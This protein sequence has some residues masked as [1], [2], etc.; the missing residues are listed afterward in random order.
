MCMRAVCAGAGHR[1][2]CLALEA[3]SLSCQA[4]G[5]PVGPWRENTLCS[6]QCPERSSPAD[7]LDS[8]SN[9]CL[10][11]LQPGSSAASCE[12]GCQ[13]S[14][15]RVF[16]GG[17]CVPYSQC[18][19][20]LHDKYIK[21]DELLYMKD[22]TQRCW[23][24]PLGGVMCEEVSCSPGQQCALRSGSWGCY[25]RPEVCELRGGLHVSTL[26]GQLLHLEPQLSYSLMSVCDE[27]SVQWFSLISYHGPCDGS[28]SRL[29][30]VFQILLHGMSLAI[31]QG[32]V[33]VNGHFVSLP[34][35]LA[36]GLTLTSGVNQKKSEVTVILRRDA[37]LEWELQIDIGVTMVTVKVPLWYSGKLCGLC[38]NLN[39]LYSHNS[40]KSW[41]LSDFPG[42]GCSG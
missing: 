22:C 26:S 1:A 42:C 5:I 19:C 28:S 20:T 15:D 39:D 41:V 30:T 9:S 29:V 24:H 25:E 7:C 18:G 13:C 23:C 17:E 6:L 16:D 33:K 34:H 10:A 14:S 36:S 32:T 38:G 21:T 31:Q 8:S 27:A 11:L 37:G 3:Y 4:K 12:D 2:M 40:V 35:T